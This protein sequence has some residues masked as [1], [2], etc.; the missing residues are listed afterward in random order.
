MTTPALSH[1]QS[2][3]LDR[4]VQMAIIHLHPQRVILFGSR[5]RGD[6]EP[7]SDFDIAVSASGIREEDWTRFVLEVQ[8][9][10]E[11]LSPV[12]LIW[13]EQA[14]ERLSRRIQ[15]EGVVLYER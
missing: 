4:I 7:C 8:E 11:T 6:A 1:E 15:Q 9:N 14:S 5:A 2:P 13:V 10:L 12:D 3:V